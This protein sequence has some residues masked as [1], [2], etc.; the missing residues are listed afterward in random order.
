MRGVAQAGSAAA[1]GA[2]GRWFESSRPDHVSG[3]RLRFCRSRFSLM[4]PGMSRLSAVRFREG[5][6]KVSHLLAALFLGLFLGGAGVLTPVKAQSFSDLKSADVD[7]SALKPGLGVT[8]YSVFVRSIRELIEWT[9]YKKGRKGPPIARLDNNVGKGDVLTSGQDDGVGAHITG[10]L[11]IDKPG[12]Y[13]FLVNSNDGVRLSLGGKLIYED[14]D[15]HPDRL[16]DPPIEIDFA[17]PGYYP[18][19]IW[20]FERK[21][22]STLELLW[23]APGME[24]FDFVPASAFFHRPE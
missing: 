23:L 13:V 11:R 5:V 15:V 7:A 19:D 16:S 18:I 3:F 10:Y 14:P 2:A 8:Y 24:D 21:N 20:Y 6:L 9:D 17:A 4:L 22:T 1:L 12:S